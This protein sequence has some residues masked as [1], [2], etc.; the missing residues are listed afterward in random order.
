MRKQEFCSFLTIKKLNFNSLFII[1]YVLLNKTMS[2]H[3]KASP[4][5]FEKQIYNVPL[6]IITNN[7][8]TV[9]VGP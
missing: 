5:Y 2:K 3:L 7:I 9:I 1:V 6:C 4:V 8:V